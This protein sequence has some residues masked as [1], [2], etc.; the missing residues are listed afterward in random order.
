[1]CTHNFTSDAPFKMFRNPMVLFETVRCELDVMG[2]W[3]PLQFFIICWSSSLKNRSFRQPCVSGSDLKTVICLWSESGLCAL[4]AEVLSPDW[5]CVCC[6][7]SDSGLRRHEPRVDRE[8]MAARPGFT[9][10][11]QLLHGVA[12]RRSYAGSSDQKRPARSAEDGGQLPQVSHGQH[13]LSLTTV[14][15]QKC[16]SR[17]Y[18]L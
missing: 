3:D 12:G 15:V 5:M 16:L 2:L 9:S 11:P 18:Q 8:W 4:S 7:H 10:V 14:W 1:M 13:R 6:W 17:S